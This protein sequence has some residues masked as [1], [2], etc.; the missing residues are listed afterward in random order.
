[1]KTKRGMLR[2]S[3]KEGLSFGITS[4]IITT[5][6]LLVGLTSATGSKLVAITGIITIAVADSLSDALGMHMS[7]ESDKSKKDKNI[8]RA[9]YSTFITKFIITLTFLIP[10][11]LFELGNAI[12]ISIAYGLL[13]L[14]IFSYKIARSR[15]E[16]ARRAITEH[17]LIAI[18]VIIITQLLGKMITLMVG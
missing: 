15:K 13:I 5:L 3:T 17:L 7:Q 1:M 6:G 11:L 8:W 9:T 14:G 12:I 16:S 2:Q 10:V 4:A 18:A